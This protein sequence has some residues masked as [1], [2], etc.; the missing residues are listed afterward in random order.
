MIEA[1]CIVLTDDRSNLENCVSLN[2]ETENGFGN[3]RG[4]RKTVVAPNKLVSISLS[5]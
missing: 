4:D 1:Y 3:W 5:A 2:R